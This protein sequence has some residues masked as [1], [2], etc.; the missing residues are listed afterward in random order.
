[1]CLLRTL[2]Q[3]LLLWSRFLVL[4]IQRE[5]PFYFP[6]VLSTSLWAG[7]SWAGPSRCLLTRSHSPPAQSRHRDLC[8]QPPRTR[9]ILQDTAPAHFPPEG[10]AGWGNS[11]QVQLKTP[12]HSKTKQNQKTATT[13]YKKKPTNPRHPP[14]K[15]QKSQNITSHKTANRTKTNKQTPQ[16][17]TQVTPLKKQSQNSTSSHKANLCP[18]W[19]SGFPSQP[20]KAVGK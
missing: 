10:T 7:V 2:V 4:K 17:K 18:D 3:R 6:A 8:L 1:M 13:S 16:K 14:P 15:I 9:S 12:T 5:I 11:P 20:R 19:R